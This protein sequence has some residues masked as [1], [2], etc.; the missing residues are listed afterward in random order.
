MRRITPIG[1]QG[2]LLEFA[3]EASAAGFGGWVREAAWAWV[4]D[5]VVAY[6]TV[7]VFVDGMS[8]TAAMQ[9]LQ[10]ATWTN[11]QTRPGR[12]ITLPICYERGPDLEAVASDKGLSVEGVIAAHLM[13]P[14]TI[15][16]IG[17]VPGFPYMGYLPEPIA[18]MPRL[19]S[20][21]LR[22]EPGSVG[23][24]GRQTGI[25]P[26]PR[27]GGWNII[28]RTPL[29]IVDPAE[30]YFPL[31]VGDCVQFT[32]IDEAEFTRLDGLRL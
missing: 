19:A 2:V 26:L 12:N 31:Q 20:P 14:Y 23:I 17:F 28:G 5:V 22:V 4:E 25:Y 3:D 30:E 18:G 10:N 7:A 16:A 13:Q 11:T 9:T 29:T 24:T 15:Y 27:P 32:R 1:D 21:R 6:R 8:I